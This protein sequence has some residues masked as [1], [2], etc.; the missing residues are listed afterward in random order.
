MGQT[1]TKDGEVRSMFARALDPHG[2]VLEPAAGFEPA[3]PEALVRIEA[4][5]AAATAGREGEGERVDMS[6]DFDGQDST[7]QKIQV[8][9]EEVQKRFIA[10]QE[11][12]DASLLRILPV[13][14]LNAIGALGSTSE[15]GEENF[16]R[17]SSGGSALGYSSSINGNQRPKV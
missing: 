15:S 10:G 6:F 1:H 16:I 4:A 2:V 5:R 11:M 8:E 14:I 12:I 3:S 17:S 13:S 7:A 9:N